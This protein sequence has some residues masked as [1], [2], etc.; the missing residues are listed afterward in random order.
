MKKVT[1][2]KS[3]LLA[4]HKRLVRILRHGFPKQRK[5]EAARQEKEMRRYK[6]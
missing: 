2:E 3:E 1:M 4:E 5:A 6:K